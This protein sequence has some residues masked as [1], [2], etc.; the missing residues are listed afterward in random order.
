MKHWHPGID[1]H[2]LMDLV[3]PVA[4]YPRA[5]RYA[6]GGGPP[7]C[8][9][10]FGAGLRRCGLWRDVNGRVLAEKGSK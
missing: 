3:F 6:T 10:A 2:V 5:W 1:Y 4:D 8:A 9:M 7:G